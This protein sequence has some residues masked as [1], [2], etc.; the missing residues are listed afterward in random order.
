MKNEAY[1]E[2]NNINSQWNNG[3]L[4]VYVN[5]ELKERIFVDEYLD[6]QKDNENVFT[7][8]DIIDIFKQKYGITKVIIKEN[9]WR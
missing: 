8:Y 2:Y 4:Y 5:G 6:E 7:V 9:N 3:H 1:I